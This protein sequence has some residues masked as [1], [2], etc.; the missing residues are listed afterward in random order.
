[1]KFVDE[2]SI[3]VH[4]GNGGNGFLSGRGEEE[5]AG[6]G[7]VGGVGGDGGSVILHA[8]EGV[9]TRVD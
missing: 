4:A 6:G 1:M 9:K 2:A 3:K 8:D 7:R 5:V